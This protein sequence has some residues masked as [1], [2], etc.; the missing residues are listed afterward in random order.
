MPPPENAIGVGADRG[1]YQLFQAFRA[2]R[3]PRQINYF[4]GEGAFRE[5]AELTLVA[6]ALYLGGLSAPVEYIEFTNPGHQRYIRKIANGDFVMQGETTWYSEVAHRQ[7][8]FYISSP[9]V[10]EG[11]FMVAVYVKPDNYQALSLKDKEGI[12]KLTFVTNRNWYKDIEVLQNIGVSTIRYTEA[13]DSMIR[14]I[15]HNR[16]D[17]MLSALSPKDSFEHSWDSGGLV[18]IT[19]IRVRFPGSRHWVISKKHPDGNRV[20]QALEKGILELR[21]SKTIIRA[22]TESGFFSEYAKDWMVIN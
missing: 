12:S 9:L 17:A 18:P 16:V 15:K 13:Y 4:G 7:D 2:G 10:R 14:M 19:G 5:S 3:D 21:K 6:Q 8:E 20:Y 22:Y 11:E 1:V